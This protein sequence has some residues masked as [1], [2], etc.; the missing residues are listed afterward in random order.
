MNN[1]LKRFKK[2]ILGK[3]VILLGV[4]VSNKPLIKQLISYGAEVI[5]CDKNTALES[6]FFDEMNLGA[7]FRLGDDY[8][9]DLDADIIFKTPGIRGDIPE[10]LEAEARGVTVTSE[11]EMFFKLCPCKI[12]GITGSDG[13]T[14]TTTLIYNILTENEKVCHLGGNIGKPLLPEIENIE[15][16]EIAVVE[17]SSFQLMSMK[18]SPDVAVIT[19]ISPNHLDV[20]KS[21]EEYINAKKNI[22][23]H[24]NKSGLLVLNAKNE[25]TASFAEEANGEVVFFGGE[26]SGVYLKDDNIYYD[27]K[28]I[29]S[30]DDIALP[31]DHNV[32]NYMA[33]IAAV[34]K[35]TSSEAIKRVANNFTGVEHRIEFVREIDGVRFYNDS[36]ASTPTRAKAGLYAFDKKVILIAGGYDKKIPFDDFGEDIKNRVKRLYLFGATAPKIKEAVLNAYGEGRRTIPIITQYTTLETIVKESYM[37]AEAGDVVLLSP[38][39]ASFDMFKNFEERGKKFKEC[40]RRL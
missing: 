40:V 18:C 10:L 14:T 21:L 32:E 31:G 19:N 23:L 28:H 1:K 22:F 11:M 25:I 9:N 33:A 15:E 38:G 3:K 13:K 6:E 20:H 29:I 12:I 35:K 2:N 39:C 30:K 26:D 5:C 17:L 37:A 7:K 24:Q 27:G 16:G 36:I 34:G 4:G 8:L